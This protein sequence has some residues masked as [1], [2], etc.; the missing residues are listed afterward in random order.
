MMKKILPQNWASTPDSSAN[1]RR[2]G[3]GGPEKD[4]MVFLRFAGDPKA[5]LFQILKS[6]KRGGCPIL[7]QL[8]HARVGLGL[9]SFFPS[10]SLDSDEKLKDQ[11]VRRF[12]ICP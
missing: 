7:A 6:Q 5:R 10:E 9:F 8:V 11:Y 3:P 12:P 2:G 4:L 1:R